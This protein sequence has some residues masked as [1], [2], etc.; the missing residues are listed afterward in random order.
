MKTCIALMGWSLPVIES[1]KALN[2]PYVVVTYPE[3]ETLASNYSVPFAPFE[4]DEWSDQSNV[5]DLYDKLQPYNVQVAVPLFEE[6]IEWAGALNALYREDPQVLD[7][8]LISKDK[9][10]MKRKA[11][12]QGLKVGFFDTVQSAEDI[13]TFMNKMH[14]APFNEGTEEDQWVHL[15]P[16]ESSSHFLRQ[17]IKK[18]A[19]IDKTCSN[20]KFPCIVE[21]YYPGRE[22]SCQAFIHAGELQFLNIAENI[23]P[24][25]SNMIPARNFLIERRDMVQEQM[26]KLLELTGREYGML[27]SRWR[28]KEDEQ[29]I[30]YE[31]NTRMPRGA[32]LDLSAK[33]YSYDAHGAYALCYDP[34]TTKEELGDLL[35][36]YEWKRNSY[37][38]S[39]SVHQKPNSDHKHFHLPVD[40][41]ENEH[42]NGHTVSSSSG[43]PVRKRMDK[44]D[45]IVF[46]KGDDPEQVVGL[47]QAY[48]REEF[49][50]K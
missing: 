21:S 50:R 19:E 38:G 2:R 44:E 31:C 7:R 37:Y 49:F 23:T 15:I 17:I 41:V 16:K 42:Y 13:R 12:Y 33:S 27:H 40:L 9:I 43:F 10:M 39:L 29:F 5:L 48:E 11:L 47:L 46:F 14:Q 45:A 20:V 18:P 32:V 34:D 6:T 28:I 25:I 8:A 26:N 4:L 24:G 30:F 3:Y 22:F 36:N 35:P 1:M